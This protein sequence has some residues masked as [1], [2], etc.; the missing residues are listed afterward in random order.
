MNSSQETEEEKA[1]E[2][3]KK[4]LGKFQR[5]QNKLMK[6]SW[7]RGEGQGGAKVG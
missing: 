2:S 7:G 5:E 4:D 6:Q 3:I 1:A